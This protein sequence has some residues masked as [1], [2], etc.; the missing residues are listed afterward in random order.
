[1][2]ATLRLGF[3]DLI[4]NWKLGLVMSFVVGVAYLIYL[5]LIG[6]RAGLRVE[7]EEVAADYLVVQEANSYG[8]IYGSRLTPEVGEL[9]M[10]MGLSEVIPEIHDIVGTSVRNARLLRGVDLKGYTRVETFELVSGQALGPNVPKR[11]AMVG[12]RLA[13]KLNVEPGDLIRLRGR[14]FR[15]LGV[16]R[17]QTYA[18][19]EA[20]VSLEDAQDLLGW[21]DD[22]S[23]YIIPEQGLLKD[24]DSL[25]GGISIVHRG[26][27][28]KV[29]S[30]HYKPILEVFSAVA[31]AMGVATALAL[32]NVLWR[33]AWIR[34]RE[35]AILRTV[36]F[37]RIALAG[38]L[39]IQA[40]AVI[41]IGVGIGVFGTLILYTTI[42]ISAAGFEVR[43]LFDTRSILLG[44]GWMAVV[45]FLGVTLPVLWLSRLNLANLLRAE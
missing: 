29:I 31:Q 17:T 33:L 34:R 25:P 4:H 9:L 5:T 21:S 40:V 24:G 37:Q 14:D 26:D 30:S 13:E 39:F 3:K 11:S 36:G 23:V 32:T 19:N 20:W 22:V 7:F 44:L 1:M 35:L 38:Y 43:P 10:A 16:F 15:I 18:D 45:T 28:T 42:G 41:L 2:T 27:T 8:E 12:L 6:Y